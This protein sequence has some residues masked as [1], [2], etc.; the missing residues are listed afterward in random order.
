MILQ[1][2][3]CPKPLINSIA[4]IA[5]ALALAGCGGGGNSGVAFPASQAQAP[6]PAPAAS[7]AP[8]PVPVPPPAASVIGNTAPVSNAG[9]ALNGK[10]GVAV[11]LDGNA[12]SDSDGDKLNFAW[13]LV[14]KPDGSNVSLAGTTGAT[15]T[16]T[17]DV[18]GTYVANLVVN[19]GHVDSAA[20]TVTVTVDPRKAVAFDGIPATL[21]PN[22]PSEGFQANQLSSLGDRVTLAA[23]TPRLLSGISFVMSSWACENGA[24]TPCQTS[25]GA[26]FNHPIK[27]R[28]YD[29]TG[30]LIAEKEQTFAIPYRP[31]ADAT[32]ANT[33]QWKAASG[34]CYSGLAFKIAFDLASLKVALPD[35]FSYAV[36]F[37]TMSYG[38]HP[39]GQAGGYN[40]LNLGL[41]DFKTAPPSVG[42]DTDGGT[43]R[44]NGT[45]RLEDPRFPNDL[46]GIMAQVLVTT[47]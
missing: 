21:K 16:F 44:W 27:V 45:M 37:D 8:V 12:S 35:T 41:Y 6:A 18:S 23:D 15:T 25:E 5:A 43:I 46:Y 39:T 9:V 10:T 17:P 26:A 31:S 1:L 28:F 19:D 22:V 24:A 14:S 47:P 29:A 4:A 42:T 3:T 2:P 40:S 7:Q 33:A 36:S 11:T 13:T 38:E 30:A 32:C 20:S 34:D